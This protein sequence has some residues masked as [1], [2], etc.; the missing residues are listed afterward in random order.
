[1]RRAELNARSATAFRLLGLTVVLS[2]A[3]PP[4][5]GCRSGEQTRRSA[6][7]DSSGVRIVSNATPER[8]GGAWLE[9]DPK[10][11][12]SV[13]AVDGPK[14]QQLF[15][16]ADAT[17]LPGGVLAVL[18]AGT[19]ELRFYD[20]TGVFIKT[21]GGR[22]AGPG[23]FRY[24]RW[25]V[26]HEDT[27][28]VFD[29]FQDS[30]RLSYFTLGGDFIS[31]QS[32]SVEGIPYPNPITM[33]SD[34][35]LLDTREQGSIPPTHVGHVRFTDMPVHYPPSGS[36]VDTIASVPGTELFR[37]EF[38]GGM[39]QTSVP[40]GRQ[41]HTAVAADRIYLGNGEEPAIEAF[42]FSGHHLMSVRFP[43]KRTEVTHELVNRW[44]EATL[45]HPV[46]QA[47]PDAA[48]RAR[49]RFHETPVPKTTPAHGELL[50]DYAGRLWVRHY[51]PPWDSSN[52]WM[53]F[54]ADG[55]WIGDVALPPGLQVLEVGDGYVLGLF[56]DESDVEYVRLYRFSE[57]TA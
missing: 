14:D 49:R 27:L 38:R 30:G 6:V 35:T 21:V 5:T 34:G 26:V 32:L 46:Y 37:E 7:S 36:P 39:S 3:G 53:V 13:G 44:I 19:S 15:R 55:T 40:F 45:N 57:G 41:A 56:R 48:E 17:R 31:S 51:T 4:L 22:G 1:M 50:V 16:V 20:S 8:A 18:N 23:E 11:A 12:G 54:D 10:P 42:D 9:V 47:R 43:V 24:P 52:A 25:L 2:C 29:P 33:L 28:V